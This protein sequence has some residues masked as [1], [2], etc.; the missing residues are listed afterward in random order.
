MKFEFSA[1]AVVYREDER[2]GLLF[3]LLL[4]PNKE[5]D[6]PKGHIEKGESAE[7]A[8]RREIKEESGLEPRFLPF[9][10]VSTK[11]F[12]YSKKQ[13]ILKGV[14]IFIGKADTD[15]VKI[16][17][18][19]IAYEW[20]S[21]EDAI[22]KL[23]FKNMKEIFA[24]VLEYINRYDEMRRLDEEYSKLPG[25]HVRW[26][27]SRRHVPGE[28]PLNAVVMCVGQAPGRNEDEQLRPFIGR[29]GQLLG[30]A[31]AKAHMK[32]ENIYITNIVPFF[33]PENRMPT[34]E[35]VGLCVPFL[36]RQ[37]E[38][39]KPKFIIMWG[40]LSNKVLAGVTSVEK[41]H[42]RIV[43]KYGITYM[44]TFH[45]AAGLRFKRIHLLILED[46]RRFGQA[47]KAEGK[48]EK[49]AI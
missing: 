6:I 24:E 25:K 1:G 20:L 49:Q 8:A 36:R 15:K 19:H 35:E 23:K 12:F 7:I 28:G 11:Y 10:S 41:E 30:T 38:L 43:E 5:Y 21:Y 44:T 47:I 29:S 4:K 40:S 48:A 33:P 26:D 27:L 18:E 16:S 9:F 34:D 45:P 46:V 13:K 22:G 17:E 3:L 31:L 42:G 39:V 32:R 37:I 2:R 14:K